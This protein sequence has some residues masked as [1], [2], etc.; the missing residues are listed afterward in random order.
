MSLAT[1][2]LVV[3][4]GLCGPLLA[5]SDK[6]RVPVVIGELAAGVVVGV[7]GTGWLDP[8]QPTFQFLANIG[9]GMVMFVA[10]S[11]VP[12]RD[13]TLLP[14]VRGGVLRLV[15]IVVAGAV[16]GVLI[17]HVFGTGHAPLYA[18]LCASSSAAVVLPIADSLNLAG[19]GMVQALPQVALADALGIIALP[20]VLDP[21]RAGRA[22]LGALVVIACGVAVFF[23]LREADKRGWWQAV[24]RKSERRNFALE[25][26][27]SLLVLLLLAALATRMS[28]SIMLAGFC[29]GLAVA[30]VGEPRRLASQLFA[31]SEGVFG[32]IF[33]VWLGASLNLRELGAHPRMIV[34]G[35]VL[36][37]G[38]VLAHLL[39]VLAKQPLPF[40]LLATAQLGLPVAA[41]TLGDQ[42]G[43]LAP[44]EDAALLLGAL[45]TIVLAVAGGRLAGRQIVPTAA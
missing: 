28:V 21:G 35:V 19:P 7:T 32:P 33:F 3:A 6:W 39:G 29:L 2:A 37:L 14:Q 23:L 38:A 15:L 1:L 18:V 12:I 5:W 42:L 16:L 17:S 26:R 43:L 11:H 34:L 24:H 31:V 4:V 30:A 41:A 25:L 9:F 20:L 8:K 13:K 10:G 36:A 40:A 27:I 22:G 45:L 44:G